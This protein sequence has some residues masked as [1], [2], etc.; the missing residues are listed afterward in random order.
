MPSFRERLKPRFAAFGLIVMAVLGVLLARLWSMQV[1][2]GESYAAMAEDNRAREIAIEA[3]R[4]RI[5]DRKGR[6]LVANRAS[7]TVVAAPTVRSEPEVVAALSA[8]LDIP[9]HEIEARLSSRKEGPLE[10]RTLAFDVPVSVV[11][12]LEE[13]EARFP[14]VEVRSAAVRRYPN[15]KL[16][17]HVLGYT[18]E[19]S[20]EELENAT[21]DDY[22]TGDVV[23][24]TGAERQ[25]ETVLRGDKGFR[26]LEVDATG[27]ARRVL[28]EAVAVPGRDVVL[29]LD[30]DVQK[31]AEEALSYAM[32]EARRQKFPRAKAG[33]V[34]ALDVKS[35]EVLAMASAPTYDPEVFIGGVTEA[36]WKRLNSKNSEYPLNNRAVMAGYPPGSTF[37]VITGLAGLR[38]GLTG[39]WTTFFC[40]GKWTEMGEQ[41]PKWCWQKRGHGTL[42]F[43]DGVS[44]SCD[45]VFYEIGHELYRRG[46][47]EL[48][49]EA[50]SFGLGSVTGIDLPGE[51]KGRVP[52]AA[53]KRDFNE[54]YPEYRT[55]L[56]GDT[57]NLAIGQGDALTTPLQLAAVYA[58][59]ANG[60]SV[61]SPHILK[62]VRD[63]EGRPV[64]AAE[65]KVLA[66]GDVTASNLDVI[67]RSLVD[68][69]T[70]GTAKGAFAGFPV[71]VAGKTG[72]SQVAGKD[73]Y[74]LFA[75]YAP[76]DEP[77]YAVAIVIEQG[78][79]GGSVAAPA[80]RM[81]L[82][83]LLGL[84]VDR[85]HATDESR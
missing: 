81:V 15:R 19:I 25:F 59:L 18:G 73:D 42:D 43:R 40:P 32:D 66:K 51:V 67:G 35:G 75:A 78:G 48:Q 50:R 65:R 1:L 63:A 46:K 24:K 14:G 58:G 84:R 12:Y 22:A 74:A 27:R 44:H 20:E 6:P 70:Q 49:A 56:P 9:A 4:G 54:N 34:V 23:G 28:R 21:F 11:A 38:Q 30:R 62:E 33:A 83:E 8:L 41:W 47:E 79:H 29:T 36:E 61:M 31:V 69:T 17:A 5:L 26:L 57:V 45:V 10:P 37:K 64:L 68:V 39:E 85:V 82:S 53:W 76:A 52:D 3:P 16:G 2:A 55:W 80:A 13:N 7:L 71:P 72:T 60:G 77:R